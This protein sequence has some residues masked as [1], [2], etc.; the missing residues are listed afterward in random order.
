MRPLAQ[1][2]VRLV[3]IGVVPRKQQRR[4]QNCKIRSLAMVEL[5]MHLLMT[6]R[7]LSVSTSCCKTLAA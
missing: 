7:P 5:L 6:L 1:E 2:V 4:L 3:L